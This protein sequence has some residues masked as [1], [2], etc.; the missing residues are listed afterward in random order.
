MADFTANFG[1][2]LPNRQPMRENHRAIQT[3]QGSPFSAGRRVYGREWR[4]I[5]LTWSI[6]TFGT[7]ES[8][9]AMW[10]QSLGGALTF[11]YTPDNG[12]STFEIRF[13]EEPDITQTGPE[14]WS[15]S[16]SAEERLNE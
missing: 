3:P 7:V 2:C 11:D 5:A 16:V 12:E 10:H 4:D 15:V 14:T 13:S 1:D 8:V 6:A 9:L